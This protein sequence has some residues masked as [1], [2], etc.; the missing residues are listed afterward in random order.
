MDWGDEDP[1]LEG[2]LENWGRWAGDPTERRGTSS[3]FRIIE[4]G[5]TK[6]EAEQRARERHK[7][8]V[9]EKDAQIIN[10]AVLSTPY[11][12][13]RDRRDRRLFIVLYTSPHM[14]I[15]RILR[16]Y[17][18]SE[19]EFVRSVKRIRHIVANYLHRMEERDKIQDNN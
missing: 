11:D 14:P 17:H 2:R 9:D 8:V 19:R 1:T 6:E 15:P 18:V 13:L 12:T 3:L 5:M 7:V 16:T 4:E 10:A